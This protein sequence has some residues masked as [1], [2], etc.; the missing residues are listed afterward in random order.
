MTETEF[1]D[2]LIIALATNR[3][4]PADARDRLLTAA[5]LIKD[6]NLT[7]WDSALSW[8]DQTA[9]ERRETRNRHLQRAATALRDMGE[10]PKRI[11]RR[12]ATDDLPESLRDMVKDAGVYWRVPRTEKQLRNI[13]Q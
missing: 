6:G 9:A 7:S 8:F 13:L 3:P 11:P 2:R 5:K 12:I 10:N 1:L 4:L